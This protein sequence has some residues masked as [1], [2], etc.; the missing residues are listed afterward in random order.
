MEENF[1]SEK[2]S[3]FFRFYKI[4]I[5]VISVLL[6]GVLAFLWIKLMSFQKNYENDKLQMLAVTQEEYEES[7]EEKEKNAQQCFDNYLKGMSIDEWVRL[8]YEKYPDKLDDKDAVAAFISEK[9]LSSGY[10]CYKASGYSVAAPQYYL[11]DGKTPLALFE[12][13]PKGNSYEVSNVQILI[14]GDEVL[15]ADVPSNCALYIN[16][17]EVL[18][19]YK[20]GS[21]KE[22]SA[23]NIAEDL[24]NPVTF[25]TYSIEGLIAVPDMSAIKASSKV[26][27]NDAQ[28]AVDGRFYEVLDKVASIEYQNKAMDF[29]QSLLAYYTKGKENAESNMQN[30]LSHV[31]SGSNASKVI[32]DSYSG[33]VWTTA[34]SSIHYVLEQSPVYVIADNCY[35]VDIEYTDENSEDAAH[36]GGVYRVYLLDKGNGFG[37]VDFAG[38][39]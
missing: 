22:Y 2:S 31:V 19:T 17:S 1:Y 3:G 11:I 29:V 23:A 32:N 33:I 18:D 16:G 36:S 10:E 30:V 35:C 7:S 28:V 15:T 21:G 9:I 37:I 4:Y 39:K 24:V 38:I 12:L 8:W 26:S 25:D 13:T 5:A 14:C 6:L 34:D 27:G 20:T